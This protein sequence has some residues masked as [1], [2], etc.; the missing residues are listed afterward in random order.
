MATAKW[1]L[2]G[3]FERPTNSSNGGLTISLMNS[4]ELEPRGGMAQVIG[5]KRWAKKQ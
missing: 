1:R 3:T 2:E 5:F 4:Y